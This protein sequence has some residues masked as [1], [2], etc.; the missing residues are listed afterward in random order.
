MVLDPAFMDSGT[1]L[2]KARDGEEAISIVSEV[3]LRGGGSVSR[4]GSR[5]TLDYSSPLHTRL[6]E[7]RVE[8]TSSPGTYAVSFREG[9]CGRIVRFALPSRKAVKR[10]EE[11]RNAIKSYQ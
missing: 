5:L 9:N 4:D 8:G 11:I 6:I 7:A 3:L 10:M 1:V 2:F